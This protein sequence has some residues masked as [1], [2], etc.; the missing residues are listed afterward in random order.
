MRCTLFRGTSRLT[1][2]AQQRAQQPHACK[3]ALHCELL[4]NEAL[5]ADRAV[6]QFRSLHNFLR[7]GLLADALHLIHSALQDMRQE[8]LDTKIALLLGG[9]EAGGLAE[10]S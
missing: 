9:H 2:L 10:Q 7:L 5:G 4:E 3:A 1:S 8:T 6:H